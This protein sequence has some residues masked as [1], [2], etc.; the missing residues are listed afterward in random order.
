[1]TLAFNKDIV[2]YSIPKLKYNQKCI[3]LHLH[4]RVFT[5]WNTNYKMS[6]SNAVLNKM[7]AM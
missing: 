5:V 3:Y 4:P 6:S 2:T 7:P 1:M